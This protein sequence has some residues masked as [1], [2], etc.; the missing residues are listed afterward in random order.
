MQDGP[1][2]A[3]P[4]QKVVDE[5]EVGQQL[6]ARVVRDEA[7]RARAAL[8]QQGPQHL[9]VVGD[10]T[11]VDGPGSAAARGEAQVRAIAPQRA[12]EQRLTL[13]VEGPRGQPVERGQFLVGL[14]GVELRLLERTER[15][16]PLP[17]PVLEVTDSREELAVEV[18]LGPQ[19]GHVEP[20]RADVLAPPFLPEVAVVCLRPHGFDH[21]LRGLRQQGVEGAVLTRPVGEGVT[22]LLDERGVPLGEHAPGEGAGLVAQ[23]DRGVDV[24]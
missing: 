13:L 4:Q 14:P 5:D 9:G 24:F 18:A 8:G 12:Q 20:G 3:L 21:S 16:D 19:E 11:R 22:H 2:R 23:D 17:G 1:L 15:V 10:E 6:T 7:Q